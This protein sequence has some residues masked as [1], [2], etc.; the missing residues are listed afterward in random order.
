MSFIWPAMLVSLVGVPVLVAGYVSL[1]RRRAQRV[2][3]LAS[4]G[5]VPTASARRLRRLRHVPVALFLAALTLLLVA[6]AR[7]EVSFSLPHREGTV[8]LA[9]DVSNSMLATD[10]KPTRMDAAKAAAHTF[11]EKQPKEIKIGVVAFSDGGLVTQAP[12]DVRAD[13]LAAIDRLTPQG[14]TSLGH[15]IF[16]ALDAIAG[17]PISANLDTLADDASNVDIGYFGSAAIVLLS[18]GEN[19]ASPDPLEVAKLASVAGVHIYTIGIGSV[20]GTVVE[21][22]GFNVAT[23]LDEKALTDIASVTNGTYFHAEDAS[24]LANVYNK[25]DLKLT[26]D[27]KKTEVTGIVTGISALLLLLGGALSLVWFGRLV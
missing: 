24:S 7:P 22:N 8:I 12:T 15:G 21:I 9:F 27:G 2:A 13:V 17:K 1:T 6:F 26:S 18:D 25:I 14:A 10:L 3:E 20:N 5:F 4:Q 16:T 19:T 11:V 23:A